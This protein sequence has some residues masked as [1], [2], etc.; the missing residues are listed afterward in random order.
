MPPS[1]G[2]IVSPTEGYGMPSE[3]TNPNENV[4]AVDS[5]PMVHFPLVM[6]VRVCDCSSTLTS[7]LVLCEPFTT[8]S[9][10][11]KQWMIPQKTLN[12]KVLL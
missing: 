7:T 8:I 9:V 6:D 11:C 2:F 4:C 10:R 1:R 5:I 3:S 12:T